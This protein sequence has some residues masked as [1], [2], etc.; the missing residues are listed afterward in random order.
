M[1]WMMLMPNGLVAY[2][3]IVGKFN[4]ET[5]V[6]LLKTMIVPI[7]KLNFGDEILFQEDNCTVHKA[8]KV[9]E[10]MKSTGLT[11]FDWP[12]KSPDLNIVEDVWLMISNQVYNGP[13]FRNKKEL[14]IKLEKV[15]LELNNKRRLDLI[16][17]YGQIRRRMCKI[18]E[19]K[20]NLYNKPLV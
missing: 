15:I 8:A 16:N 2:R 3:N 4:S 11:V 18:L 6:D 19:R 12:A 9:K 7:I 5:Y 10:F 20:G 1:I 17:L 14:L 13:S